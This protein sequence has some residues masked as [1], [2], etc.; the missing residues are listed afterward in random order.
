MNIMPV[1][2]DL[3]KAWLA[4]NATEQ[5]PSDYISLGEFDSSNKISVIKHAINFT[6]YGVLVI[7]EET[8]ITANSTVPSTPVA[9]APS[10]IQRI[11]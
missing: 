9:G 3:F 2:D 8:P 5:G 7:T 4:N 10:P 1:T 6:R 11:S